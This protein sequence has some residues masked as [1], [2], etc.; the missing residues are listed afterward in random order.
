M[1]AA[2]TNRRVRDQAWADCLRRCAEGDQSGLSALYDESS[3]YVYGLALRI[4]R[5][6]ADAEEITIDV[7]AQ[8]WRSAA[9][10]VAQRGSVMSWLVTLTR[11]RAID[12]LR[13]QAAKG[14][15]KEDTL[16]TQFSLQDPSETPEESAALVQE[17]K[18]IR[19]ALNQLPAEQRELIELAYYSGLSHS[20]LASKLGQPLGTVKTRIRLGMMKLRELLE[21]S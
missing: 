7:Y 6:T 2:V 13:T 12:R 4:L 19:A 16:D 21:E 9:A 1:T 11:S 15:R 10:F 17:R 18:R 20:E 8:V 14:R 5:D 3:R